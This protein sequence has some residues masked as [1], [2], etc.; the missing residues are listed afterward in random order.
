MLNYLKAELYKVSRQRWFFLGLCLLFLFAGAVFA[1]LCLT[2]GWTL[3]A[4][5]GLLC[6]ALPA[7]FFL[8]FMLGSAVLS[9]MHKYQTLKNETSF[10]LSR[11]RIYLGKLLTAALISALV[12][13]AVV[14]FCLGISWVLGHEG[15]SEEFASSLGKLGSYLLT[16]LPLWLG[17]LGF[18]CM[19]EFTIKNSIANACI[20]GG[21]FLIFE[22]LVN[23]FQEFENGGLDQIVDRLSRLLL[24][25]PLL[26]LVERSGPEFL[27][28]AW[29]VGM[30]WLAVSTAVGLL[31]FDRRGIK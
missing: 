12:C 10:G 7:G 27:A 8:L 15:W 26:L 30:G 4:S 31:I 22:P 11:V 21:Y 20:Y 1:A 6:A 16:A 19:L 14:G 2:D 18:F 23:L 25:R 5:A 17:A 9:D 28:E 29:V 3:P 13:V 24:T